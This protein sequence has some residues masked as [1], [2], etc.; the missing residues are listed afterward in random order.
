MTPKSELRQQLITSRQNFVKSQLSSWHAERAWPADLLTLLSK[1]QCVGGYV[2]VQA[3]AGLTSLLRVVATMGTS[4][5]LPYL[6]TREVEL[7]FRLHDNFAKLTPAPYGF[8]QPDQ[9]ALIAEP[10]VILAP[11]V[12]FD[13]AGHRLG[14]GGGHYDRYFARFPQALRIGVA[15]SVQEVRS[16][17]V[18]PWD[19]GLDAVITEK[20]WIIAANS[21]IAIE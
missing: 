5:A 10:D 3:E 11:L 7:E 18:D 14:Q 16:I 6:A 12:G 2:E 15:W 1:A 20:E 9:T 21:R 8:R 19:I 17:E 4:I 13:R